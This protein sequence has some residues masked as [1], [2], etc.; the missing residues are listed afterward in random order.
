ML[1]VEQINEAWETALKYADPTAGNAHIKF[2]R[3]IE[4]EVRKSDEALIRQLVNPLQNLRDHGFSWD[5]AFDAPLA[6]SRARLA[7]K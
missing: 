7:Q 1:N 2:A 6:A 4:A 5:T 3:A